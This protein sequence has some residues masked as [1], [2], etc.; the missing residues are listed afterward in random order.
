MYSI[1]KQLHGIAADFACIPFRFSCFTLEFANSY[2]ECLTQTK[3]IESMNAICKFIESHQ[4][5]TFSDFAKSKTCC[6]SQNDWGRCKRFNASDKSLV[7]TPLQGSLEKLRRMLTVHILR[8]S[9]QPFLFLKNVHL[10]LFS[11]ITMTRYVFAPTLYCTI[12][13]FYFYRYESC[14]QKYFLT[15]Y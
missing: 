1:N 15:K 7:F 4:I 12:S 3:A 14:R 9:S 2:W 11:I 5:S 13:N 8:T 10:W 6:I